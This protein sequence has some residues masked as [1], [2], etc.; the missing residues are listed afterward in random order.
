MEVKAIFDQS[1]FVRTSYD[2]LKR[3]IVQALIL[4]SLVILL[5]L[6]SSRAVLIAAVAIP[7]SFAII[8]IVFYATGQTL[9]AF[10]LGGLMLAMGPL[11]DISVVV[12]E[13]IH[14]RPHAGATP[15]VAAL[16]GTNAVAVP[17]LAAT[18]TT[19]AVLLPVTL[20]SG[21]AK[22]LFGPLALTVV[23]AMFAGY[24]VSMLVTPLACRYLL[25]DKKPAELP[26]TPARVV[27]R[28]V[29]SGVARVADG[30]AY[31][32]RRGL[33]V[34]GHD[35]GRMRDAGGR[36]RLDGDAPAEHVLPG[37]RRVDGAGLRARR[38]RHLA[39]GLRAQDQ[40][41]GRAAG[42]GAATRRRRAG[43]DERG[44]AR[45]CPQRHDQPQRRT[46]HGLHPRRPRRPRAPQAQPA[47][48]RRQDARAPD[49]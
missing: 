31:L 22:K 12:L 30:Y 33:S 28:A 39:R 43:A 4:I 25:R 1:T 32:L 7:I 46:A 35:P 29:A 21:L 48:D 37:D 40:R 18:L 17:A 24:L 38:A 14:R 36:E 45:E 6:Q 8:L 5:F 11:V 15:A 10:T 16:E 13:S 49:A 26:R 2:G 3:E 20:L 19:V 23:A 27:P 44:L 41:H 34:R 47:A 9:N 42:Q